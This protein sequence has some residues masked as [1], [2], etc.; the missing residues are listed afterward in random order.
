MIDDIRTETEASRWRAPPGWATVIID[1]ACMSIASSTSA[2][3]IRAHFE[4]VKLII[5]QNLPDSDQRARLLAA[6]AS[7]EASKLRALEGTVLH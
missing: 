4:W 7:Y 6:L 2:E 3:P 1:L 5:C